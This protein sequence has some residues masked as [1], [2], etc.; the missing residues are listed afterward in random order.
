VDIISKRGPTILSGPFFVSWLAMRRSL[1]ACLTLLIVAAFVRADD[2][3]DKQVADYKASQKRPSLWKRTQGRE[4][5][6]MTR[7]V[8]AIPILASDY[9][10]AEKPRDQVQY[11]CASLTTR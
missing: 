8:R 4:A 6:A 11:L 3:W 5:L 10:S 7:D 1:T 9:A 2:A